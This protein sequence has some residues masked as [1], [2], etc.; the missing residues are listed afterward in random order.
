MALCLLPR[1]RVHARPY[2]RTNRGIRGNLLLHDCCRI[3]V[4]RLVEAMTHKYNA[5]RT[6]VDGI[7]FPSKAEAARY[8]ELKQLR[9]AGEIAW[10][11]RQPMFDLPGGV[12]YYADF[13]IVWADKTVTVEDVKGFKTAVY[14]IKKKQVEALYGVAI[15][16]VK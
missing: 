13:L 5:K 14:K 8:I 1:L 10:F 9:D 7:S 15:R 16:E 12:K 6:V 4:R 11:V 2:S 3:A